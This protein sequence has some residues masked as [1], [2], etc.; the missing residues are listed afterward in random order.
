MATSR[1]LR[2]PACYKSVRTL[3]KTEHHLVLVAMDSRSD[4]KV[5]LKLISSD[6]PERVRYRFREEQLIRSELNHQGI[7]PVLDFGQT[8]SGVLYAASPYVPITLPNRYITGDRT[9]RFPL[10]CERLIH[11][12]GF[13][14]ER[15]HIHGDIKPANILFQ[16]RREKIQVLQLT[17]FMPPLFGRHK[18]F[19]LVVGTI[20]YL[21]PEAIRGESSDHRTDLYALGVTLYEVLFGKL[22]FMGEIADI[23]KQHLLEE[24]ELPTIGGDPIPPKWQEA[25]LALL[26]KNPAD[27]PQSAFEILPAFTGKSGSARAV[28]VVPAAPFVGREKVRQKFDSW[29]RRD[30]QPCLFI[31]GEEGIGKTRLL[32][33]LT[34]DLKL[35]GTPVFHI[36]VPSRMSR[37]PFEGIRL[38]LSEIAGRPIPLEV[39]RILPGRLTEKGDSINERGG[40]VA[41]FRSLEKTWRELINS[42]T[43]EAL[44]QPLIV[45]DDFHKLDHATL[46]FIQFL[47]NRDEP[48]TA[49]FLA[50]VLPESEETDELIGNMEIGEQVVVVPLGQ[51]SEK[52]VTHYIQGIYGRG[53]IDSEIVKAASRL[54]GNHPGRLGELVRQW[55]REGAIVKRYGRFHLR[56]NAALSPP[57]SKV[58]KEALLADLPMAARLICAAIALAP[59]PRPEKVIRRIASISEQQW[60]EYLPTLIKR[61]L[62]RIEPTAEANLLAPYEESIRHCLRDAIPESRREQLHRLSARFAD[63]EAR[64]GR[65]GAKLIAAHHYEQAG[66][67]TKAKK[68]YLDAATEL[69]RMFADREACNL[70]T[71]ILGKY[72]NT[73]TVREVA[74]FSYKLAALSNRAGNPEKAIEVLESLPRDLPEEDDAFLWRVR[75]EALRAWIFCHRGESDRADKVYAGLLGEQHRLPS[76][77]VATLLRDHAWVVMTLGRHEEAR[78]F[79]ERA[80]EL[81]KR[82]REPLLRGQILNRLGSVAISSGN[83][84][85][86]EKRLQESV[87]LLKKNVPWEAGSSLANLALVKIAA[88][89]LEEAAHLFEEAMIS[90]GEAGDV[91]EENRI[92]EDLAR[93]RCRLGEWDEADRL[94]KRAE[95]G[96]REYGAEGRSMRVFLGQ[97][98]MALDRGRLDD[99]L[100]HALRAVRQANRDGSPANR[101]GG[102][103]LLTETYVVREDGRKAH[104]TL[105][106]FESVLQSANCEDDMRV[107]YLIKRGRLAMLEKRW[108]EATVDLDRAASI[109]ERGQHT[110]NR[111][112]VLCYSI[113]AGLEMEDKNRVESGIAQLEELIDVEP[114]P[115]TRGKLDLLH[116]RYED[117]WGDRAAAVENYRR[118][119]RFFGKLDAWTYRAEALARLGHVYLQQGDRRMARRNLD[120]ASRIYNLVRHV[121]PPAFLIP[122]RAE[123]SPGSDGMG[124]PFRLICKISE[125]V[126]LMYDIDSILEYIID[127]AIQYLGADRGLILLQPKGDRLDKMVARSLEGGDLDDRTRF[128]KTLLRKSQTSSG[129]IVYENAR[130]DEGFP[131]TESMDAYNILSVIAAPLLIRGEPIGLI[132]LDHCERTG[133]FSDSDTLFLTEVANQTAMA[134]E[135]ARLMDRLRNEKAELQQE[136]SQR[137]Q[138]SEFIG[139]SP[140]ILLVKERILQG[141]ASDIPILL[142]GRTGTGKS[143]LARM[144]HDQSKRSDGPFV[145][146][147]LNTV[148]NGLMES[149]LFGHKEGAYTDA[150]SSRRGVFEMAHKGTLL[151]DEIGD[152]PSDSQVKL[153]RVLQEGEFERLGETVT[154]RVDV[155]LITATNKDLRSLVAEGLF[156]E[157]LYFRLESLIIEIPP[158]KERRED[159]EPLIYHFLKRLAQANQKPVRTISPEAMRSLI[160]FDWPGNVRELHHT[161][162]YAVVFCDGTCIEMNHL[163]P[164]VSGEAELSG[165]A[166]PEKDVESLFSAVEKYEKSL[167]RNALIRTGGNISGAAR[168]L[169]CHEATI[170]KKMKKYDLHS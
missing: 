149:V 128:S 79:L 41:L 120:E 126:N 107:Y 119:T 22:P 30:E 49:R 35:S 152:L 141:A 8:P 42:V 138:K 12:I 91:L 121:T 87:E 158:L 10:F 137:P 89:M 146:Q 80:L 159:I 102:L 19:G 73:L 145:Q 29:L 46:R 64:R 143:M 166:T 130:S 43:G 151:L 164:K 16:A 60:T 84:R 92:I 51:F 38:L 133:I 105:R 7:S 28:R 44:H 161:I 34:G 157:D 112:D 136:I 62:I 169:K 11:A 113:Q 2:G 160:A 104:E 47:V 45:I 144:V 81:V 100:R 99:A 131:S 65:E 150:K 52:E 94:Y 77:E 3:K 59:V 93:V 86:A 76:R 37:R 66:T 140:A 125:A 23:A 111:M 40:G 117:Q 48:Q 68:R 97:G 96:Y 53:I 26:Q 148:P 61:R 163:P 115:F 122:A 15:G 85:V 67:R 25:L 9:E 98:N 1:R 114:N 27:R 18:S 106:E 54:S 90:V 155:R 24:I 75:G 13:L 78:G 156:R 167:I 33:N 118:A 103:S 82:K 72:S 109:F 5:V 162:E 83:Y 132:Y 39:V 101:V 170:R 69:E 50:A 71:S 88:G 116:G 153:L 4:I 58:D 21:A 139:E 63:E 55:T 135:N 147:T 17:D 123:L 154:R 124:E 129:P 142:L 20:A 56:D 134:I 165:G 70:Y 32:K 110:Y 31:S 168:E 127:E 95:Q 36:S 57:E 108:H 6:A 74:E 14:H